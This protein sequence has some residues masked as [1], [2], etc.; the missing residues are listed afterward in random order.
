[1]PAA[2]DRLTSSNRTISG[3]LRMVLAMAIRC[4]SPPLTFNPRS[5]TRLLYADDTHR[6]RTLLVIWV[7]PRV[8]SVYLLQQNFGQTYMSLSLVQRRCFRRVYIILQK[9]PP[10]IMRATKLKCRSKRM[11]LAT[12]INS[13]FC[14]YSYK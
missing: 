4:F 13:R 9:L 3:S 12:M 7:F 5:P 14:S 6:N 2:L 8:S 1:M 10:A 11:M